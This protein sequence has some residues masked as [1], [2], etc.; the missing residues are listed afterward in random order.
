[1][2][3]DMKDYRNH[4]SPAFV[5]GLI[6]EL[7]FLALP[8]SAAALVSQACDNLENYK[9]LLEAMYLDSLANTPSNQEDNVK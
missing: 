3:K 7:V 4:P 9:A 2:R 5:D 6:S 1:M 8:K